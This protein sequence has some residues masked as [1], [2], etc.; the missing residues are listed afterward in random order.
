[1]NKIQKKINKGLSLVNQIQKIR[2]KNN[3]NWMDLL[4]LSFHNDS[5]K[6]MKIINSILSKD[7]KLIKLANSLQKFVKKK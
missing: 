3:K 6:T 4:R 1:M 7:E 5:N 2:A